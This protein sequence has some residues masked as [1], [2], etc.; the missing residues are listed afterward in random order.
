ME[1]K[2]SR[3]PTQEVGARM[4]ADRQQSP[5]A[6]IYIRVSTSDQND[7]LQRREI[8]DYA[9]RWEVFDLYQD[10]ASGAKAQG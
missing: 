2:W 3:K 1:Q 4:E 5:K 10:V 9:A 6:A 7:E 8:Q